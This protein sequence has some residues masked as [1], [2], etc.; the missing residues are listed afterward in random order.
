[1]SRHSSPKQALALVAWVAL[2]LAVAALGAAASVDAAS[3]YARLQRPAW[4]PPAGLFG[5][6]WS[7][8]YVTMG[9]ASWLVWRVPSS[10][11]RTR[12]LVLFLVQL[13]VNSLWS[14]LFF[15]WRIG[16]AAFVDVVAL[17]VLIALTVAAFR[18]VS[19]VAAALLL[20][21]LGWVA[22][23]CALTWWV[24]QHNPAM[25]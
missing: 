19:N 16:P 13:A 14:W 25:L 9:I 24:W 17:L 15:A 11:L 1:M 5:P 2:C 10:S 20:P 21:Y 6:V 12:A 3:F 7:V 8:L 18:R 23:A 4:A 22:F